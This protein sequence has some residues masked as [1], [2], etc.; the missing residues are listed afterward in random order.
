VHGFVRRHGA[1]PDRRD[2]TLERLLRTLELEDKPF[3]GLY[4]RVNVR[5]RSVEAP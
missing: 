5:W 4:A 2:G 1:A 3:D